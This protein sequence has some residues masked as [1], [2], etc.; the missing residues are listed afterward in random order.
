[1]SAAPAVLHLPPG[2]PPP[3]PFLAPSAAALA[4]LLRRRLHSRLCSSPHPNRGLRL[5]LRL[6]QVRFG[7]EDCPLT[8]VSQ[9]TR[10]R[11]VSCR[12]LGD[13]AVLSHRLSTATGVSGGQ[14]ISPV[15][16]QHAHT[17]RGF[18]PPRRSP[19]DSSLEELYGAG[20]TDDELV[21]DPTTWTFT[22]HDGPNHLGLWLN[23]MSPTCWP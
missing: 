5:T 14:Q 19:S 23:G 20:M 9:R 15:R 8:E 10:L 4:S 7:G 3:P 13:T 21:R 17:T 12:R 1:M 16:T 6:S 11:T 2:L 22:R 18:P